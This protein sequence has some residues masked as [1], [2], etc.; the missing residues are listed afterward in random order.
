MFL[1]Q[2]DSAIMECVVVGF[3]IWRN[4]LGAVLMDLIISL[5]RVKLEAYQK[6]AERM[7]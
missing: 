5:I 4:N 1:R 6:L 7:E 3:L 2:V